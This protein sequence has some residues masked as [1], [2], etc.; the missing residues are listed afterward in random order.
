MLHQPRQEHTVEKHAV[1]VGFAMGIGVGSTLW[2]GAR[3]LKLA[4]RVLRKW[5]KK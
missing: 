2:G 1:A 3:S 4:A 5:G